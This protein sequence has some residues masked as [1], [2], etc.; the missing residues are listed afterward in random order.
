M[1]SGTDPSNKC[2]IVSY[3]IYYF[4][5]ED[6]FNNE[7]DCSKKTVIFCTNTIF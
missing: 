1:E 7:L 2:K 3:Y 4:S 6:R 5:M